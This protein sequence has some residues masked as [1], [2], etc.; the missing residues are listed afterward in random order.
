LG[1]LTTGSGLRGFG[2]TKGRAAT[3]G[4]GATVGCG[5]GSDCNCT[6]SLG[7]GAGATDCNTADRRNTCGASLTGIAAGER[8]C[9]PCSSQ[10]AACS[11]SESSKKSDTRSM[12][13]LKPNNDEYI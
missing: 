13:A 10:P 5:L 6:G 9:V 3:G 4:F 11:A 8:G 1:G 7:T 2:A 12:N